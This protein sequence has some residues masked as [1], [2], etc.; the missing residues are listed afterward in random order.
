M[1]LRK[2]K[3]AKLKLAVLDQSLRS[4]GKKPFQDLHI[5]EICKRVD[6]SKV[7]F[8]NYFDI[9]EDLLLYYHR[10]WCFR[11]CV[12]LSDK[13]K[14]GLAGIYFL[15][16]KLATSAENNPGFLYSWL[17]YLN[18]QKKSPKPFA[19]KPEEKTLLYP[20][21]KNASEIEI[22]SVEQMVEGFVLESILKKEITTSAATKELTGIV[23]ATLYGSLTVAH[24]GRQS[25]V[26]THVKRTLD[27]L[28]K[29][30]R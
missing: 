12:E 29:G 15:G 9:K 3:A 16:E 2:L 28:F 20:D 7:T 19:V 21:K 17:G 24:V 5:T 26:T 18:D 10:I 4:I 30:L 1:E 27:L 14:H 22:R 8:F 23:L 25:S 13:P 6:V 11:R